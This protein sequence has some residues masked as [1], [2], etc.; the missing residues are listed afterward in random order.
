MND[1]TDVRRRRMRR[2]RSRIRRM[3][4]SRRRILNVGR[5]LVLVESAPPAGY[6]SRLAPPRT[7]CRRMY[8]TPAHPKSLQD[9]PVTLKAMRYPLKMKMMVLARV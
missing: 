7:T 1:H 2:R 9:V 4:R 6:I 8:S 3:R 5:V